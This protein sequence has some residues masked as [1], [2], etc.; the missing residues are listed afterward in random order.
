M[1]VNSVLALKALAIIYDILYSMFE[2]PQINYFVHALK[3]N[4]SL[5]EILVD[6]TLKRMINSCEGRSNSI[7]LKAIFLTRYFRFF[8]LF[9]LAP[10]T[11]D[12]A[13]HFTGGDVFFEKNQ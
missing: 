12:A 2:H 5:Q 9:N 13:K 11:F 7:T 10:H 8:R 1:V 6:I 3:I 4:V